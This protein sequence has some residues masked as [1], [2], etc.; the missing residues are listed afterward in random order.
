[1][2]GKELGLHDWCLGIGTA[3]YT[4]LKG[5]NDALLDSDWCHSLRREVILNGSVRPGGST[6]V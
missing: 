2:D 5:G 6:E 1:M 3:Q 4:A